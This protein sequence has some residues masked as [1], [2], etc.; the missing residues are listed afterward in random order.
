MIPLLSI[1]DKL[2]HSPSREVAEEAA[3]FIENM[4]ATNNIL[5]ANVV[6]CEAGL[7]VVRDQFLAAKNDRDRLVAV[8]HN[9]EHRSALAKE[10]LTRQE[11]EAVALSMRERASKAVWYTRCPMNGNG[12]GILRSAACKAVEALPLLEEPKIFVVDLSVGEDKP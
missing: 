3:A 12:L 9:P 11:K 8:A 5:R 4:G 10:I 7:A 1:V 2:R 6:S